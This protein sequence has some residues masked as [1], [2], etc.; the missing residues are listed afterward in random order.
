MKRYIICTFVALICLTGCNSYLDQTNPNQMT[1]DL[2]WQTEDD[3]LQAL[4]ASY[5]PFRNPIGGYYNV[6][7]T[8][9]R[10][11]RGDDV[12]VRNDTEATYQVH[13][14]TNSPNNSFVEAMFS[15]CYSAIYRT[16]MLLD[17]IEG[18]D[19]SDDFKR[20]IRGEAFFI[21][22]V[23]YF[24]LAKEFK[25]VPLRLSASQNPDDFPMSKSSQS[26][27][28]AQV[29]SDLKQSIELLPVK[30]LNNG[31]ANKGAALAYLGKLYIYM[32]QWDNAIA[33]LE[34][35]TKSPFTYRLTENYYDNFDLEHEYN[36]ESIFEV[37]YQ[38]VGAATDR[39]GAETMNTMMT[40]P[41]N[42]IFGCG[43]VG[44]WDIC[45]GSSKI[46][47]ML[48]SELDEDNLFDIRARLGAAWD[49]PGC[50]YYLN[51]FRE[52]VAL[53]NQAKL[54]IQKY[55]YS[56]FLAQEIAPESEINVRAFR[57]ANVLLYLAEAYLEKGNTDLAISY[58]NQ[59]RKRANLKLLESNLSV[60]EV[61]K[62]LIKQ[63]AIEFFCEGER[64]YDLRRWGILE[65]EI[66]NAGDERSANFAI[67]HAYFPIPNK[68][69]QTNPL[70]EQAKDW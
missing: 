52:T 28:Y 57:Y 38:K 44:G 8:E 1:S 56:P 66:K 26:E 59:I 40:T 6:R 55:T 25:D 41:L 11:Y 21:R 70:C 18:V 47:D 48:T 53:S 5:A 51:P 54:Y 36:S 29:E 23:N 4:V 19:L 17:R 32:E 49:Y 12:I 58:I 50:S 37:T 61:R 43:D 33:T 68:E 46:L 65:Q 39:W 2:Y 60:E 14:F 27:I 69:I 34:Q 9:I 30:S 13:L 16:N 63:R 24:I 10:N 62:D 45:N 35:L 42:R 7:S 3:F 31:R 67:K 20:E 64:F 15:E 22:G